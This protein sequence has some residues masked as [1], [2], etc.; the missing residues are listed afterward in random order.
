MFGVTI[1]EI[2]EAMNICDNKLL[3]KVK[4]SSQ[5][6]KNCWTCH[7]MSSKS[8]CYLDMMITPKIRKNI[9]PALRSIHTT[10]PQVFYLFSSWP[11]QEIETPSPNT[12]CTSLTWPDS[13]NVSISRMMQRIEIS[14]ETRS[15]GS[16]TSLVH[17]QLYK[18]MKYRYI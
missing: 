8:L 16:V 11:I 18:T 12:S 2:E 6:W 10:S 17:K 9:S 13:D 3:N 4:R 7:T 5:D 1:H 14:L 15:V